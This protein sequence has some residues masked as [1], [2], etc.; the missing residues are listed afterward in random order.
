MIKTQKLS[1]GSINIKDKESSRK[2]ILRI[3]HLFEIIPET[4]SKLQTAEGNTKKSGESSGIIQNTQ[5]K[6][7]EGF[8]IILFKVKFGTLDNSWQLQ[9]T[10]GNSMKIVKKFKRIKKSLKSKQ[11]K[12]KT[13]CQEYSWQVQV[14]AC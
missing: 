14:P 5:R 12:L 10:K 7:L 6:F 2:V 1:E 4:T 9:D 13:S 11:R 3:M 8:L